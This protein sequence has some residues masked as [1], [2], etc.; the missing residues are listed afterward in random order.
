MEKSEVLL[1]LGMGVFVVWLFI[2]IVYPWAGYAL[3]VVAFLTLISF[4]FLVFAGFLMSRRT[5]NS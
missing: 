3:A 2:A 4:I 5:K 1:F